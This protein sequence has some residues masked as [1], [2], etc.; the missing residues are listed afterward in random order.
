MNFH[1]RLLPP[2]EMIFICC[3]ERSLQVFK[4]SGNVLPI[5]HRR[6]YWSTDSNQIRKESNDR[7]QDRRRQDGR[8]KTK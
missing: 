6:K 7:S 3:C 8:V 4:D 1:S 2:T 5:P